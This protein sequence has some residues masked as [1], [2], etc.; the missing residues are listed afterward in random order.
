[1]LISTFFPIYEDD[2]LQLALSI[3]EIEKLDFPKG[4]FV[5]ELN[6]AVAASGP[7]IGIE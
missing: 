4:M 6:P 2:L 1:V 7:F 3:L 5:K